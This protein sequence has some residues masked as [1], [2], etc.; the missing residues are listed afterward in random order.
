VEEHFNV[1]NTGRNPFHR[2]VELPEPVTPEV[3]D[4]FNS[5]F[6]RPTGGQP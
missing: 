2:T 6:G 3:A 5:L 4:L 1:Y